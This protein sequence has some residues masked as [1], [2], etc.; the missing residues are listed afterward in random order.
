MNRE[1][2]LR[3]TLTALSPMTEADQT[4]F[5]LWL[6]SDELRS[7]IDDSRVPGIEDQMKW[8]KRAQ[9]ADR[10]F[11]SIITVPDGVLIGNCGYVDIDPVRQEATLR[12][13]IGNPDYVGKGLGTDA[14]ELLVRYGFEFM[15][16]KKIMLKVLDSNPRAIRTYEKVG[17]AKEHEEKKEGKTVLT[18]FLMKPTR[19]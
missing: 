13:T 1:S 8:Y 12:I 6:Q 2:V 17:F 3:G 15:S 19:T 16:L 4:K 10:K 14:V 7:L 5:C 9:Q 18:M 11:F